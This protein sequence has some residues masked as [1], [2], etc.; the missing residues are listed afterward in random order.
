[1][2]PWF[3]RQLCGSVATGGAAVTERAE[4]RVGRTEMPPKEYDEI[5]Y[6][7]LRCG[8]LGGGS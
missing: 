8:K 3:A 7:V 2:R 5:Y 4:R 6:K 1:V